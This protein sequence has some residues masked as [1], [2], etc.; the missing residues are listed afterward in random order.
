MGSSSL[1]GC[2]FSLYGC[3]DRTRVLGLF[4]RELA[5]DPLMTF[6]RLDLMVLLPLGTVGDDRTKV[7][8][9]SERAS[10]DGFLI[11]IFSFL[12]AAISCDFLSK[13]ATKLMTRRFANKLHNND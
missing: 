4:L 9:C 3:S 6:G 8:K 1:G 10:H 2:F 11:L 5:L 13:T 7:V 12:L